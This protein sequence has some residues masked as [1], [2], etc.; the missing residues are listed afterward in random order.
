M[1][2]LRVTVVKPVKPLR[3]RLSPVEEKLDNLDKLEREFEKA[4][5]AGKVPEEQETE[6][7]LYLK[8]QRDKLQA[9]KDKALGIKPEVVEPEKVLIDRTN[10]RLPTQYE[11]YCRDID[12]QKAF[13]WF[14]FIV[15]LIWLYCKNH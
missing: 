12:P 9:V 4:V 1:A 6:N 3:Y 7:R 5:K 2:G 13:K 11:L 8:V 14:L 10:D 15:V